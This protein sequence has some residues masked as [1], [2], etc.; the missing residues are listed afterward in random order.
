MEAHTTF[1]EKQELPRLLY[2]CFIKLAEN[3]KGWWEA[4]K[5]EDENPLRN[6]LLITNY[7]PH[8]IWYMLLLIL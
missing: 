4:D 6:V 7:S 2:K 1:D 8:S 5:R 3:A